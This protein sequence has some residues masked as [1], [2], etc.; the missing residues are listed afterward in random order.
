MGEWGM[1][2][3]IILIGAVIGGGTNIVAI[4]MLFRPYKPWFIGKF[5]VPFTPGLIPKRRG[6]IADNLGKLVEEHL[7]TPEGMQEK[8][9]DGVL[10]E[11]VEARLKQGVKEL[12]EEEMTLDEWM[13][14][15]LGKKDQLLSFR[16]NIENSLHIK[17][18][19]LFEEFKHRPFEDWVPG[20]WVEAL[21]ERFPK[22]SHQITFKAAE[23][24]SSPE[25][26]EQIDQLLTNYLQSRGNVSSFFSRFSQR[27]SLAD[28]IA[29]ELVKFLTEED[30]KNLLTELLMKEWKQ[31]LATAPDQYITDEKLN[32]QLDAFTKAVIGRTPVVGEWSAP[33]SAWTGKYEDLLNKTVIPSVM[34][35]ASMILSRYIKSIMKQI[36]I[37]D[38]VTK[39]VNMF[40][41]AR[42]EEM[43]IVIANKELKMIAV[44]GALIGAFVGM[45]QG[46]LLIFVW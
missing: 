40:P 17:L 41:L 38:L 8:L 39:E 26:R 16:N 28:S 18:L 20:E 34:A 36:G 4:R 37:K 33:L 42:L 35:S 21:E 15:H 19:E 32:A 5:R 30:T 3:V 12:L 24:V 45:I 14:L 43:L 7:V 10:F 13:E 29:R 44:L 6:Q 22:V 2:L 25:G 9:E 11:E 1:L 27:F 23:Y 31:I 46:I